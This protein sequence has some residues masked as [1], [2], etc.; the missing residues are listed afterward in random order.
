MA[1]QI[2]KNETTGN[3]EALTGIYVRVE[4][5]LLK[6]GTQ[7]SFEISHYATKARYIAGYKTIRSNE[8]ICVEYTVSNDPYALYGLHQLLVA[9][10]T[11]EIIDGEKVDKGWTT[12]EA[13]SLAIVDIDTPV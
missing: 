6:S 4:P 10:L 8:V 9:S 11:E 7:I 2:T 5:L 13:N 12:Y 3:G 1:I